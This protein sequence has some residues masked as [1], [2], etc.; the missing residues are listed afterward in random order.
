MADK[1]PHWYLDDNKPSMRMWVFSQ[2]AAGAGWG[3]LVFFGVILFIF[4]L[5]AISA[6]LPEDPF[7]AL[8]TGASY[9]SAL[10]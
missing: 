10:V 1:D 8:E 4:A 2:M 5:I 6:L 3:A 7:A 9:A